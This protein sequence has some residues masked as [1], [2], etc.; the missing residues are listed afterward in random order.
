MENENDLLDLYAPGGMK[1]E[2][3]D[4]YDEDDEFDYDADWRHEDA[5]LDT[6]YE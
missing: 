1:R 5:F 4:E 2:R 3:Y 6:Q